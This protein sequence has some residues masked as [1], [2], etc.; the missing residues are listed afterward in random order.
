MLVSFGRSETIICVDFHQQSDFFSTI[1]STIYYGNMTKF[2]SWKRT[3]DLEQDP[4]YL[5][6]EEDHR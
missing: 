5:D 2:C 6:Q 3:L 4:N 1:F